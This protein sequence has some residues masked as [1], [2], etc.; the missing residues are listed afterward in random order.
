MVVV[1]GCTP[2]DP[3]SEGERTS[4]RPATTPSQRGT[5]AHEA[6][7][8]IDSLMWKEADSALK[9]MLEFAASPEAESLNEFEGH[10]CQVMVAE[11]LFKNYYGQSNRAE[12]LKAVHYFDSIVGMDGADTRGVSLPFLD[13][14]AHYI[15]GVGYYEQ[16]NLINSCTEYLTTLE[17]MESRFATNELV[18]TKARFIVIKA[19]KRVVAPSRW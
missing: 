7:E 15:N 12:V 9:V 10:Y 19:G 13:A 3:L 17:V 2:P 18:G 5:T 4:P 8:G 11:L 16:G 6:L 14:R 1:V